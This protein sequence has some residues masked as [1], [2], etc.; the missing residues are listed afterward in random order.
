MMLVFIFHRIIGNTRFIINNF[1]RT[2]FKQIL[3][4]ITKRGSTWQYT[5]SRV[6][7][8]KY[9]PI[10]KGGFRTKKEAAV[11]AAQIEANIV[12]GVFIKKDIS[13]AQYFLEWFQTYKK[14]VSEITLNSYKSA[15]N[16]SEIIKIP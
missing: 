13:F 16:I 2:V 7:N 6:E 4:S 9:K 14:D 10:R 15:Y 12:Q 1:D 3:A 5:V 8:G 11:A